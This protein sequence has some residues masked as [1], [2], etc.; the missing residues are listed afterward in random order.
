MFGSVFLEVAIG[1]SFIYFLLSLVCT[2]LNE[3]LSQILGMRAKNLE[4]GLKRILSDERLRT[5]FYRHPLIRSLGRTPAAGQPVRPSYIP[6]Q[7]FSMVM[8]DVVADQVK[9]A[10]GPDGSHAR[11]DSFDR[12]RHTVS[13]LEQED[14]KRVLSGFL[15]VSDR[16]VEKIRTHLEMWFDDVMDRVSGTYKRKTQAILLALALGLCVVVNADTIEIARTLWNAPVIRQGVVAAAEKQAQPPAAREKASLGELTGQLNAL[17]LPLGWR[18]DNLPQGWQWLTK[19][20]GLMVTALAVS[21]G[22][23]FWFDLL[24][25]FVRVRSS[26]KPVPRKGSP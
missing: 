2:T 19:I 25:R 8:M 11:T 17:N 24:N 21:L 4:L 3:M 12:W 6:P 20:I 18:L 22:A 26:V 14:I 15:D 7:T 10:A 1:I 16:K 9:T 13:R 5:A 23:P